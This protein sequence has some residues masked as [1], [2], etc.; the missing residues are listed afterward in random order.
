MNALPRHAVLI[1]IDVQNGFD[2]PRWGNRNN[3][4]AEQNMGRLLEAFRAA[5]RPVIFVQHMSQKPDSP[6]RAGQ[7]GND[8]KAVVAPRGER[9]VQKSAHSA[10]VNTSL[11]RTL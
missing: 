3:P 9:V 1:L 4:A 5:G 10:L 2:D 7:P 8:I 11:E 6:L